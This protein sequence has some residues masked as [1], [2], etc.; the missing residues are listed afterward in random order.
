MK[1]LWQSLMMASPLEDSRLMRF[2]LE[3]SKMFDIPVINHAEDVFFKE[4]TVM[5]ESISSTVLGLSGNPDISE[6]IMVSRD[7]LIADYVDGRIHVPHVS[8]QKSVDI[9]R[10]Y[11]KK[12]LRVTAETTPH[13]IFFNDSSLLSYNPNLKVSPPIKGE[14]DR[15]AL[16]KGIKDGTIDCIA[17]DHAPHTLEE[18]EHDICHAACGM[19]GLETSFS[20][21]YT[22]LSK[23]GLGIE[24]VIHL[25]INGPMDII[26]RP[27]KF[28]VKREPV[29]LV[30]ISE[31]ERWVVGKG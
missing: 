2:A 27:Q 9:I 24:D 29:E 6:S 3:Y 19:I 18:K 7:L 4:N 17:S 28:L 21:S 1:V 5:N 20:A 25:F 10:G 23:E 11:K 16:I 31:K 14:L 30:V 15:I 26:N 13:H 22:V 8:S 12:G